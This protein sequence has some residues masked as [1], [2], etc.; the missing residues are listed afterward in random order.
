MTQ[1]PRV[2]LLI[3]HLGGGGAERVITL[4]SRGLSPQKYEL[5]LGLI[6]ESTIASDRFLPGYEFMRWASGEF[7]RR[8]FLCCGWSGACSQI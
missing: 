4:L 8:L 7:A 5:H 2:L 1:R 3:P 6:T